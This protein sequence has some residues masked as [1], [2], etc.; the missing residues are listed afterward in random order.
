MPLG[1]VLTRA[2]AEAIIS[3][4]NTLWEYPHGKLIEHDGSFFIEY[5]VPPH[6]AYCEWIFRS[7]LQHTY[8]PSMAARLVFVSEKYGG[9]SIALSTH[10]A[11]KEAATRGDGTNYSDG[12]DRRENTF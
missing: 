11:A 7:S 2:S 8:M 3:A 10:S 1:F 9:A 4:V 12:P 6:E 5:V